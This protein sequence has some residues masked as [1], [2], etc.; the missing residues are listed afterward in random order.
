MNRYDERYEIRLGKT[1][2][3]P[4]IMQFI[5]DHW[6]KNHIL[7]TDRKLFEYEFMENDIVNIVLAIDKYTKTIEA[8]SG[9]LKCS[10]IPHKNLQ[11]IWGS[12][13][14]VNSD[15]A[16]M[17]FLGV[18]IIKR[19]HEMQPFRYN[20]G[21]GVNPNT[22]IP[23]RKTAFREKTAK[24]DHY[25]ALNPNVTDFKIANIRNPVFQP[26]SNSI[27]KTTLTRFTSVAAIKECF[28]IES[29]DAVPYKDF[30]YVNKRF[31]HHPYYS[32][33]VYGLQNDGQAISALLVTRIVEHKD[34]K[35][36]RIVDYIGNQELF[37]GLG[38]ALHSLMV[39]EQYEYIDFYTFGFQ[40]DYIMNA[41]FILKAED[42][43]NII[44]NYFEPYLRENVDIWVRYMDDH[45]LFCKADGDQDRPN[46]I[47][48]HC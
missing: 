34:R 47:P 30:W 32:Y 3:I 48:D 25:Y 13:W 35:V 15:R 18:E 7:A 40:R 41:G 29:L 11:D 27:P 43:P 14:K 22:A 23:V 19:L 38:P 28:D 33:Q 5:H 46:Q 12:I 16:N 26:Y 24:M 4:N 21:I 42:D 37:S 2:D 9:F 20:L 31:F 1:S 17:T 8:I 44:P 45:V 6:K 39:N 36:L 10:H